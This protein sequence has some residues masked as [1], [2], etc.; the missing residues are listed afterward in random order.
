MTRNIPAKAPVTQEMPYLLESSE[1]VVWITQQKQQAARTVEDLDVEIARLDAEIAARIRRRNDLVN[2]VARAD[3]AGRL[4]TWRHSVASDSVLARHLTPTFEARGRIDNTATDG[5]RHPYAVSVGEEIRW[6]RHS[7]PPDPGFLRGV[8]AATP[9]LQSRL[10]R[11]GSPAPP[12]ATR[13]NGA[14]RTSPIPAAGAWWR[15]AAAPAA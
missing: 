12:G 4:L 5:L 6:C 1:F 13:S 7:S 11:T 2:I 3:A 15:R 8:S 14:W 10:W 9:S